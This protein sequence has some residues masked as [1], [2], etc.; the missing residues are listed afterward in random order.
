LRLSDCSDRCIA[1]CWPSH[2]PE[3]QE[4]ILNDWLAKLTPAQRAEFNAEHPNQTPASMAAA[5]RAADVASAKKAEAGTRVEDA[6][7][8]VCTS[9]PFFDIA[10]EIYGR[11]APTCAKTFSLSGTVN[12]IQVACPALNGRKITDDYDRFDSENMKGVRRNVKVPNPSDSNAAQEATMSDFPFGTSQTTTTVAKWIGEGQ[13]HMPHSPPPTA[14]NGVR[15]MGPALV[16]WLD[17]FRIVARF[18]G[19]PLTAK[20]AYVAINRA[21]LD[22]KLKYEPDEIALLQHILLQLN[23]AADA[24]KLHLDLQE[25]WKHRVDAAGGVG[26][27]F[28][29]NAEGISY[30]LLMTDTYPPPETNLA[31]TTFSET[32]PVER[33]L[34]NAYFSQAKTEAEKQALLRKEEEKYKVTVVDPDFFHLDDSSPKAPPRSH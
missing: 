2:S 28:G 7:R 29:P 24:V 32:A 22:T 18:E 34:W 20:D 15:P 27:V 14:L 3:E 25:P 33:I 30:N 11:T 6:T 19:Q 4:K 17:R 12:H 13:P 16:T 26:I 8:M 10:K 5:G 23:V 21:S 1:K 9:L 31:E